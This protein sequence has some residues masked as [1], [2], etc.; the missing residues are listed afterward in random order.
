MMMDNEEAWGV[1]VEE[2]SVL[3]CDFKRIP[4]S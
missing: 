3:F 4:Y 2:T 1:S